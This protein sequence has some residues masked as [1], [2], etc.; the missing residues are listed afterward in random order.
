MVKHKEENN[1]AYIIKRINEIRGERPGKKVLQKM[2]FL[3][4]EKGVPLNYDFGLH[5]YGPYSSPLNTETDFLYADGIIKIDYS[6]NSHKMEVDESVEVSSCGL[7]DEQKN[8]IDDVIEKFKD[9]SPSNLE[10]LT[11]AIY[12]YNLLED[13]SEESIINGV[14]KIKGTKYSTDDIRRSF[15]YFS[16]FNKS[17]C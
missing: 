13:K 12:A 7:T 15:K 11:T 5:F 6:G 14:V 1:A 4:I 17:F 2:V 10:L 9:M 8:N 16:F 3:M